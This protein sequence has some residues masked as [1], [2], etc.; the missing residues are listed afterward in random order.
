[1]EMNREQAP[2]PAREPEGAQAAANTPQ[3]K[4]VKQK[5]TL[6]WSAWAVYAV[7]VFLALAS[8]FLTG[9]PLEWVGRA[10]MQ[11]LILGLIVAGIGFFLGRRSVRVATALFI[12]I[13]LAFGFDN[14]AY[15][16]F[17]PR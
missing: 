9:A 13:A 12:I 14:L 16:Y 3:E 15:L 8:I 6:H 2:E 4:P 10:I 7:I 17:A 1:M 11:P 5:F